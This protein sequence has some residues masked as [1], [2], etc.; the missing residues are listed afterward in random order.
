MTTFV[1]TRPRARKDHVCSDCGRTISPGEM[2]RR[3]VG[4]TH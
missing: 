4:S 1:T 3:G 2:Y